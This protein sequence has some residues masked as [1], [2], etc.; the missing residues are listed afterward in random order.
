MVLKKDRLQKEKANDLGCVFLTLGNQVSQLTDIDGS[1]GRDANLIVAFTVIIWSLNKHHLAQYYHLPPSLSSF[2]SF[3]FF[4]FFFF[5]L[6][7][8]FFFFSFFSFLFLFFFSL[9][10]FSFSSSS[11]SSPGFSFSPPPSSL[12]Y[13]DIHIILNKGI[14]Y[15]CNLITAYFSMTTASDLDERAHTRLCKVHFNYE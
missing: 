4:F 6:S 15:C 11:S 1:F 14:I 10:F 2:F 8:L 12:N 9:F 3:L 7:L 13:V 5:F